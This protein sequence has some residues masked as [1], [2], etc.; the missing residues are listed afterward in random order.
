MP[1]KR[2]K[3]TVKAASG[4]KKVLDLVP[5]AKNAVSSVGLHEEPRIDP[6]QLLKCLSVLLSPEGGIKS[7]DEVQRLARNRTKDSWGM[8][9]ERLRTSQTTILNLN[10]TC[11]TT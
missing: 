4:S 8:S 1:M 11:S 3:L 10:H 2:S 7:K 9:E 5:A 6:L